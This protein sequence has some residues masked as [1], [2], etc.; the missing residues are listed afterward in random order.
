MQTITEKTDKSQAANA[1]GGRATGQSWGG[2]GGFFWGGETCFLLEND[3]C[4]H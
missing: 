2:H 4:F 3:V 1:V